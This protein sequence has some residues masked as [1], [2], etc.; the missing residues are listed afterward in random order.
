MDGLGE[1]FSEAVPLSS[2]SALTPAVS[3]DASPYDLEAV[4]KSELPR[5]I[6]CRD[7]VLLR[8]G[9]FVEQTVAT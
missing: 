6:D 8:N 4:A 2:S 3:S 1:S 9:S 7:C 5:Q